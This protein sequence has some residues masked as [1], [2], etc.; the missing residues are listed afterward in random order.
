MESTTYQPVPATRYLSNT[1]LGYGYFRSCGSL[2]S[3]D[4]SWHLWWSKWKSH[5]RTWS[6][7]EATLNLL[8]HNVEFDTLQEINISHLGKRK[9]IFKYAL[10]GGYVNSLEGIN[11]SVTLLLDRNYR[12]QFWSQM[13]ASRVS[14]CEWS[15]ESCCC[16]WQKMEHICMRVG[17]RFEL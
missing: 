2:W 1:H 11:F 9:I 10:S 8:I 7:K 5:E 16:K 14:K 15:C 4:H 17:W 13:F 12:G 6:I 3:L